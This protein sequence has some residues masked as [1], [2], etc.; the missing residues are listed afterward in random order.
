MNLRKL[1]DDELHR[2]NVQTAEK[3][4]AITLE[5][6]SQLNEIER[7]HLYSKFSC[8][9]LH[10]YCVRELKMSSGN[11]CHH[12]NAA[13]LL[14]EIPAIEEKVLSGAI[15]ITTITQAE[16]FFKR[17]AKVGNKFESSRKEEILSRLEEKSTRE[18]DKIL[19][20]ES[21][22]PEIHLRE[23]ISQ[24]S[25]S[26]TE[27]KLYFDEE[28]MQMLLRLKEVWSHAIPNASLADV[29]RRSAKEAV[30][31]NDSLKKAETGVKTPALGFSKAGIR[32]AIWKRDQSQCTF[33][34]SRSGERCKAKHFVEE[35]HIKPKAMGCD[36][37]LENIRLRC[38]THNQRHAI[39]SYG[40]EKMRPYWV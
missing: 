17:E 27:V 15:A 28:T 19:F 10:D 13:R 34:D 31:K 3:Q 18:A 22:Q 35:D 40:F 37:S 9:S 11:A 16:A 30:K 8:A 21:V 4:R 1:T 24:K 12:I 29:I 6:L 36:F 2:V 7:R 20:A 14:R 39:D 25:A 33:V 32:R 38:R 23:K 5:L 26:L